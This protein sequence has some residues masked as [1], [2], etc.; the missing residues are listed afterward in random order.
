LIQPKPRFSSP[1]SLSHQLPI[2][3]GGYPLSTTDYQLFLKIGCA[4]R[5]SMISSPP[6]NEK[7]T[8]HGFT[9]KAAESQN[10]KAQAQKADEGKPPQEAFA[11]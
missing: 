7:T 8:P 4:Y 6:L 1:S 10:C 3:T 5:G 11:L 9:Q 2:T